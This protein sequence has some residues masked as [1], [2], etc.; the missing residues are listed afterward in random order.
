[1]RFSSLRPTR[2]QLGTR[3]AERS[4]IS[5]IRTWKYDRN[6]LYLGITLRC[7]IKKHAPELRCRFVS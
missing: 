6:R 3:T 4:L 7:P 5:Y 1:M 2:L